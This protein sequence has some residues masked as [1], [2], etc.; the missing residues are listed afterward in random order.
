MGFRCIKLRKRDNLVNIIDGR[1]ILKET[2]TRN[3]M[4]SRKLDCYDSGDRQVTSCSVR[5]NERSSFSI[6]CWEFLD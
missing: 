6:E 1:I 4:G 2:D 5:G 3:G